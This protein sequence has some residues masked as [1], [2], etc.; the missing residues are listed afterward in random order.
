ANHFIATHPAS[1]FVNWIMM[2]ALTGT[3]RINVM[4]RDLTVWRGNQPQATQL[5]D[6]T[7]LRSFLVEHFGF[8]LPEVEQLRVSAIPEWA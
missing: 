8:D 7:A 6:R 3:G 4:N 2:S 1:P 5:A